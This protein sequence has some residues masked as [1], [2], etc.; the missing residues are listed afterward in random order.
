MLELRNYFPSGADFYLPGFGYC[1][2]FL[3]GVFLCFPHWGLLAFF[4]LR[5][6]Y[7]FPK[8]K[9]AYISLGLVADYV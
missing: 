1:Q 9:I 4:S 7:Q 5:E 8:Y 3:L 2:I 6:M